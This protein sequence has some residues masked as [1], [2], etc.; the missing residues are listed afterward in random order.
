MKLKEIYRAVR[1]AGDDPLVRRYH[2]IM[3]KEAEELGKDDVAFC[4][5]QGLFIEHAFDR[6]LSFLAEDPYAGNQYGGEFLEKAG[7]VCIALKGTEDG[8]LEGLLEAHGS[9]LRKILISAIG[10]YEITDW[11]MD[12]L[13]HE[14]QLE[15][16]GAIWTLFTFLKEADAFYGAED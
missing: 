16:L 3:E 10:F 12:G 7:Q 9:R 15:F 14:D 1:L 8:M 6:L 4:L 5:R 2:G 11:N 13:C